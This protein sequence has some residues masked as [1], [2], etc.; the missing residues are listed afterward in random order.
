MYSGKLVILLAVLAAC[1]SVSW[2]NP[3]MEKVD[4][5][6][7]CKTCDKYA[8]IMDGWVFSMYNLLVGV[9]VK[10]PQALS[11]SLHLAFFLVAVLNHLLKADIRL[12]WTGISN[13]IKE[14][15]ADEYLRGVLKEVGLKLITVI[16]CVLS[17]MH[18]ALNW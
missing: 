4:K 14:V 8:L 1:C 18:I 5:Y 7:H 13:M 2:A 10:V 9:G 11:Y 17:K 3:H 16:E 6:M 12:L 15:I